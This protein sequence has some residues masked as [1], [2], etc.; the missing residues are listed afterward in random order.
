M[1][2]QRT[3]HVNSG[4]AN[5]IPG[6]TQALRVGAAVLVSGQV[7]LDDQGDVVG[8]GDLRAQAVQAF[9]NLERTLAIAGAIPSEVQRLTIYVVGLDEA[10]WTVVREAGVKFLPERNP[11]AGTVVGIAA[12]PRAGLLIAIDA[13]AVVRAEFRPRR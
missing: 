11:P 12:L 3:E 13:T 10:A 7:A 9:A 6:F 8:A 4:T 1:E 2:P 5:G